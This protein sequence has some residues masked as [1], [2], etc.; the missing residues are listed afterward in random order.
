MLA[1][2][3]GVP[4]DDLLAN[5]IEVMFDEGCHDDAVA[6]FIADAAQCAGREIAVW[7]RHLNGLEASGLFSKQEIGEIIAATKAAQAWCLVATSSGTELSRGPAKIDPDAQAHGFIPSAK[8]AHR[9]VAW[10][11]ENGSREVG[12]IT[13]FRVSVPQSREEEIGHELAH[14]SLAPVPLFS[15]HAVIGR[16][17]AALGELWRQDLRYTSAVS[18][19]VFCLLSELIVATMRT[20]MP[21]GA[22]AVPGLE[23][24][25][26]WTLFLRLAASLAPGQGFDELLRELTLNIG[27]SRIW[28]EDFSARMRAAALRVAPTLAAMVNWARAPEL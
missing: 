2:M 10:W 1:A 18:A 22:I 9:G 11:P 20:E 23:A 24:L 8:A 3:I 14:A 19:K 17:S 28:S 5:N 27:S 6:T 15:Q 26:D 13:E 16:A 12:L 25:E 21:S 4:C 7:R